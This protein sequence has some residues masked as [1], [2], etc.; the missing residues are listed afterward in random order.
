MEDTLE[1]INMFYSELLK[2]NFNTTYNKTFFDNILE[3]LDKKLGFTSTMM[4]SLANS[5][6]KEISSNIISHNISFSFIQEFLTEYIENPSIFDL[7]K[8]LFVISDNNN[9]KKSEIYSKILKAYKFEDMAIQF[10]KYPNDQ[11]YMSYIVYISKDKK[12]TSEQ[13]EVIKLIEKNIALAHLNNIYVWGMKNKLNS[14]IEQLNYFPLGL[15]LVNKKGQVIYTNSIAKEYLNKLGISDSK[16]YSSFYAS[17]IHPYYMY[18]IDANKADNPLRIENYVFNVVVATNNSN[19][20]INDV[21]YKNLNVQLNNIDI[22]VDIDDIFQYVYIVD[23]S[24]ERIKSSVDFYNKYHLTFRERE[25]VRLIENGKNNKEIAEIINVSENTVKTHI[26]N[27]Y[28]KLGIKCRGELFDL[29]Y[30]SK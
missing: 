29:I 1:R 30:K 5:G 25:I 22:I 20:L 3:A 17:K 21:I 18:N 7:E 27:I 23:I 26:S 8:D 24:N 16:L 28:K 14:L 10:I 19:K 2:I 11:K 9:Y 12:F 6:K 15:M 13:I 4:A